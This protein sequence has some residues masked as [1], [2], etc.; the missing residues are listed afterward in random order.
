LIIIMLLERYEI[1]ILGYT[2]RYPTILTND[3]KTDHPPWT[4]T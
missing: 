1:T 4:W 3:N 2:G